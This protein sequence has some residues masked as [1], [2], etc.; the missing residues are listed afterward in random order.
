MFSGVGKSGSPAPRS[1]TSAPAR[2]N[3]AARAETAIVFD[4]DIPAT[5]D[6]TGKTSAPASLVQRSSSTTLIALLLLLSVPLGLDSLV[7]NF[8]QPHRRF[9]LLPT[10]AGGDCFSDLV[11]IV[12]GEGDGA[13]A[14]TA[15]RHTGGAGEV[16]W[17]H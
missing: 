10:K 8:Q 1:M 4:S 16:R 5:R 12:G 9:D 2:R 17:P 6:A 7:I 14:R 15:Q 13:R 3:C 11:E